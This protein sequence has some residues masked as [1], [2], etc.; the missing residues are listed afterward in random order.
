MTEQ[1][2]VCITCI[3]DHTITVLCKYTKYC[4]TIDL[5]RS[6]E[7][8]WNPVGIIVTHLALQQYIILHSFSTIQV[9]TT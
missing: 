7:S 5:T 4:M 8:P 9:K 2:T 1:F 3:N 6:L